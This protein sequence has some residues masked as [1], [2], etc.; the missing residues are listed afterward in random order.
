MDQKGVYVI[1]ETIATHGKITIAK[2]DL[3][4]CLFVLQE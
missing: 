1:K 4:L 2:K 3:T